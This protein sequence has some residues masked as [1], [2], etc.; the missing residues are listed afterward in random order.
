LFA[1]L[2]FAPSSCSRSFR[3]RLRSSSSTDRDDVAGEVDDFF[4]FSC[5]ESEH[6]GDSRRNAAEEPDVRNRRRKV[7]VTHAFAAH[8]CARDF[9]ATFFTDDAAETDAAVFTAVTFVIFFRTKNALVEEA[10]FLRSLRAVV[11]GFRLRDFALRPLQNA[12]R[13]SEAHFDCVKILWD[14]VFFLLHSFR[15]VTNLEALV[16]GALINF[17]AAA[18]V[19]VDAE[20]SRCRTKT[21]NVAGVFVSSMRLPETIASNAAERPKMSSDLMVRISRSEYAA[22]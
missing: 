9:Y 6:E 20:T 13:R 21:L 12:L 7:D 8:D 4:Y 17:S 10:V 19:Y 14:G 5:G 18:E 2:V 16:R 11:D 3:R 15:L 1:A 22:P